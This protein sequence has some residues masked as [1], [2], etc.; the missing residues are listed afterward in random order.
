VLVDP[1][2]RWTVRDEDILSKA[3]WSPY[4]G[5]TFVGGAVKTFLRGRLSEPGAGTFVPGPGVG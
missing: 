2:R 4:S 3:G 1:D 5:R